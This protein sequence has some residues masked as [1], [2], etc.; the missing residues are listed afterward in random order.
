MS[1]WSRNSPGRLIASGIR[2]EPCPGHPELHQ[3]EVDPGSHIKRVIGVVSK[4]EVWPSLEELI[5]LV[6][7]CVRHRVKEAH[8]CSR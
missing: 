7:E 5:T 8:L 4:D 1:P 3:S 6:T 2:R